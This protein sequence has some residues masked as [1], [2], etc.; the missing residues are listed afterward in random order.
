MNDICLKRLTVIAIFSL[1]QFN[2]F[3]QDDGAGGGTAASGGGL[4]G[5]FSGLTK[6]V[7][8]LLSDAPEQPMLTKLQGGEYAPSNESIG[9]ERDI[10]SRRVENFGLVPI[11]AYQDYA[12]GIYARLK[13]ATGVTGIPGNVYLLASQELKAASSADGN[14]YLSIA[15]VNSIET[16]DE[17]AAL[18]A[19]ELSHVVLHHHDSTLISSLQK[20]AQFFF[21]AGSQLKNNIDRLGTSGGQGLSQGQTKSLQRMQF[22]I[23]LS[24]TVVLP[25][26]TR[27]QEYDADRLAADLL[28]RTAYSITGLTDFM[29][30]IGKWEQE[31]EG[32]RKTR[33]AAIQAEMQLLVNGGN[34]D[35][36]LKVG[37]EDGFKRF[38]DIIS[39]Q[40]DSSEKRGEALQAY[41]EKH[42]ADVPRAKIRR[43]NYAGILAHRAVR[44]T[45]DAYRQTFEA[46]ESVGNGRIDEG[47]RQL[48]AVTRAGAPAASHAMPN[49]E[50]YRALSMRG[51]S[52]AGN[53]LLKSFTA[54]EPAWKP[55]EEAMR[56]VARSGKR[57]QALQIAKDARIRFKDAPALI[58]YL[59]GIFT[60]LGFSEQ[61]Q[62]E[63]ASCTAAHVIYR[64]ACFARSNR[65]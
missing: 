38:K 55:Y 3:A 43:E 22:L 32:R 52:D 16:E 62:Q 47:L 54:P 30:R 64:E 20:K 4:G 25:A 53:Q 18:L 7:G 42:H 63:L 1:F 2:A 40:H 49:Y 13:E 51:K 31:E 34:I 39:A 46:M 33:E 29:D 8:N 65:K 26:W 19:H 6:S 15:W 48:T 44:P 59:V 24:D 60:E 58:P 35:A 5:L 10:E 56:V 61:A 11:N 36:A 14:I 37:L 17:L 27:S 45:L 28:H 57:E 21:A 50:L 41:L 23:E 12:N 9:L